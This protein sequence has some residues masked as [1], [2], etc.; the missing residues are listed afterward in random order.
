[1]FSLSE[2]R[3]C[4][5]LARNG[6]ASVA[7]S[8]R[9]ELQSEVQCELERNSGGDP[10]TFVRGATATHPAGDRAD[11]DLTPREETVLEERMKNFRADPR[12]GVAAESLKSVVRERL[13]P[14]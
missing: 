7:I 11:D 14:R 6:P 4:I 8:I 5:P 13:E 9:L 3:A 1:M 12:D 2:N 10:E